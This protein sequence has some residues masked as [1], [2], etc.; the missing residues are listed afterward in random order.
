VPTLTELGVPGF[1]V[2]HWFGLVAS[3]DMSDAVVNQLAQA[4]RGALAE[5]TIRQR[6]EEIGF[7]AQASTP[8]EFTDKVRAEEARW[9]RLID[10][11][12]LKVE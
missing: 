11:R 2:T 12:G 7:A 5:E 4:V 9:K 8:D 10:E 6:F 1:A 3:S